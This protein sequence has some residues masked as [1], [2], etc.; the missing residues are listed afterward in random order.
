MKNLVRMEGHLKIQ[1]AVCNVAF[2]LQFTYI[3]VNWT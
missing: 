1:Y 2:L 3:F